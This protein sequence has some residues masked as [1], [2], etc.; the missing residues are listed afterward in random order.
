MIKLFRNSFF[1]YLISFFILSTVSVKSQPE[2]DFAIKDVKFQIYDN[3]HDK[4]LQ[5]PTNPYGNDMDIFVSVF[6]QQNSEKAMKYQ[7]KLEAFG[8]G[9]DNEA[10]GLVEDYNIKTVLDTQFYSKN[11]KY[12]PFILPYPCTENTEFKITVTNQNKKS[13]TKKIKKAFGCNLN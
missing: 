5:K 4:L 11:G 10:E 8:K 13:V 3:I 2:N 1:L 7:I 12:I 9:R 6:L